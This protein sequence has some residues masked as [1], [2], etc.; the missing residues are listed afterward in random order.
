MMMDPSSAAVGNHHVLADQCKSPII[1]A[2]VDI[3]KAGVDAIH[4]RHVVSKHHPP[5][6]LQSTMTPFSL[7]KD[8]NPT[9]IVRPRSNRLATWVPL[10][11][12][13][14]QDLPATRKLSLGRFFPSD[15]EN[16]EEFMLAAP[17]KV[18]GRLSTSAVSQENVAYSVRRQLPSMS[19]RSMDASLESSKHVATRDC[20]SR[21]S[22]VVL[23]LRRETART[24]PFASLHEQ[25]RYQ[26]NPR[27]IGAVLSGETLPLTTTPPPQTLSTTLSPPPCRQKNEFQTETWDVPEKL[28]L[29]L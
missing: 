15:F 19:H 12:D 29:P 13:S 5:R 20:E 14:P 3:M 17:Q 6:Q 7:T 8:V 4:K 2:G 23:L 16:D 24:N 26:V 22:Q 9:S 28:L 27:D 18:G 25:N 11:T 21:N 1:K 10:F